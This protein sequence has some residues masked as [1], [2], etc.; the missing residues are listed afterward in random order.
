MKMK[1]F[2]TNSSRSRGGDWDPRGGDWDPRGGDWDLHAKSKITT[3]LL[4]FLC[5]HH[6]WYARFYKY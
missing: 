6:F 1:N 3:N 2:P 5:Q 4:G